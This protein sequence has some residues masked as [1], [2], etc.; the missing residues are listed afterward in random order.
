MI[1]LYVL[2]IYGPLC[3]AIAHWD[4]GGARTISRGRMAQVQ[5]GHVVISYTLLW[6]DHESRPVRYFT[7]LINSPLSTVLEQ[8]AYAH[9]PL[10]T[11]GKHL[12]RHC[13]TIEEHERARQALDVTWS[14]GRVG[15]QL[16]PVGGR[17]G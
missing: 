3:I 10:A 11:R 5:E 6:I 9:V 4:L 7:V 13:S 2:A 16:P 8:P 1:R 15:T 17:P 12:M 14:V